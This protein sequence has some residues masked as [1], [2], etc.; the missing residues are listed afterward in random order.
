MY[1]YANYQ[2]AKEIIESRRAEAIAKAD[3][4]NEEVRRLSPIIEEIDKELVG[5]GL[6]LFKTACAGGDIEPIKTRNQE[7]MEKRRAELARLG[8]PE[9]YTD[10]GYTCERCSD[11]G[12][13]G[14]K[15]CTCLREVLVLMNIESSGMGHLINKQSFANL[16]LEWYKTDEALYKRMQYNVKRAR[17]FADSFGKGAQNLLLIGPTGTGKTHVSTAIARSVISRGF[18]VLYDSAQNIISTFENERFHSGWGAQERESEKYMECDLLIIDDL[19]TEFSNQFNVSCLYNLINTRQNKGRST[20]ISTNLSAEELA[21]K[22]EG[23]I[24]SRIAGNDYSVLMFGGRDHRI[25]N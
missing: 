23:R 18:D 22:Y 25:F 12:F 3:R 17:E 21:A 13:D 19:G 14:D 5:T 15:M 11:S 7:L 10:V 2:R 16:D 24:Y 1:S 8:L 6:L 9:D 4:R 20:I